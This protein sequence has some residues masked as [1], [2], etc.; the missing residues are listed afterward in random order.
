MFKHIVE[1]GLYCFHESFDDWKDSINA[2]CKPMIENNVFDER[3]VKK[4]F[5]SIEKF[6]P[7]IVLAPNVAMPHATE[8]CEGVFETEI[9][10][11]RVKKPV[12]FDVENRDKDARIFFTLASTDAE[13]HL[14]QMIQLATLL[15]N[16]EFVEACIKANSKEDLLE[17]DNKFC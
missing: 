4:I 13:Q 12:H 1:K 3:Y 9:G 7:Y 8:D 11:M 2:C 10:F 14:Q 17:I 16:N 15:S 6:G 5:D